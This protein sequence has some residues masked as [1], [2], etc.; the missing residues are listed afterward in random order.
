MRKSIELVASLLTVAGLLLAGLPAAALEN[1]V[2]GDVR[3]PSVP[4][5]TTWYEVVPPYAPD[6]MMAQ[7]SLDLESHGGWTGEYVFGM[8]KGLMRSTLTPALKPV[9][10]I[11][12]VPLDLAFLP[13]AAIGGF[14]R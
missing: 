10:L 13:F 4:D 6:A 1:A 12:T 8:T 2:S 7:D 11:F 14:F 3:H 5:G 9:F